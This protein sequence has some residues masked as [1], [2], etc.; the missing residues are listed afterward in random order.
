M[1]KAYGRG[2]VAELDGLMMGLAK[3]TDEE[4]EEMLNRY[5]AAA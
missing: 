3:V 4:L 1:L 5:K 2:V